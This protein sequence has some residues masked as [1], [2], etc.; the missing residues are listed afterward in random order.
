MKKTYNITLNVTIDVKKGDDGRNIPWVS[1]KGWRH[2]VVSKSNR[3][4][5]S[6][7]IVRMT[8]ENMKYIG[9]HVFEA[10]KQMYYDDSDF[11]EEC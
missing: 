1:L 3:F 7:P 2:G 10:A 4:I 6:E 8:D 5:D 9:T 11:H